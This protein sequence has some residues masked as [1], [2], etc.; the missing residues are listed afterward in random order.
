MN[1]LNKN[2]EWQQK[3]NDWAR[4]RSHLTLNFQCLVHSI[5][6]ILNRGLEVSQNHVHCACSNCTVWLKHSHAILPWRIPVGVTH[7]QALA[8]SGS[9]V[10]RLCDQTFF[11]NHVAQVSI[12]WRS[13][14]RWV[15]C[16]C[17]LMLPPLCN[18]ATIEENRHSFCHQGSR[19]HFELFAVWTSN[20]V[21]VDF[22]V[23]TRLH[24]S[25]AWR[26]SD[27]TFSRSS[28]LRVSL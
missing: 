20:A 14:R 12:F 26:G 19:M 23:G 15:C 25:L 17:C 21:H 8:E 18:H 10:F 27:S 24:S 4:W 9:W 3:N 7:D 28:Q 5:C 22:P 2:A 11:A 6:N 1:F 13:Q 16:M